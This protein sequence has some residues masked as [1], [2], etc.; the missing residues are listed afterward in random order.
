MEIMHCVHDINSQN[1]GWRA[2]AVRLAACLNLAS[3]DSS[4]GTLHMFAL[5]S[6]TRY[7][8]DRFELDQFSTAEFDGESENHD[9][10][11]KTWKGSL[12]MLHVLTS[13]LEEVLNILRTLL[14]LSVVPHESKWG[15]TESR[16]RSRG[17]ILKSGRFVT[18]CRGDHL[19]EPKHSVSKKTQG[20]C[21]SVLATIVAANPF[22]RLFPRSCSSPTSA[23]AHVVM[24][25]GDVS[26]MS[27]FNGARSSAILTQELGYLRTLHSLLTDVSIDLLLEED[28]R[29]VGASTLGHLQS[30]LLST[31]CGGADPIKLLV[32]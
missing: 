19:G 1:C 17:D 8:L 32:R 11:I 31:S 2:E 24:E 22:R 18:A 30:I 14:Q 12:G 4:S 26:A 5:Q 25:L 21:I 20:E 16:S 27:K 3:R 29:G 10:D 15:I 28:C 6:V 9:N 7:I 13:S 23:T